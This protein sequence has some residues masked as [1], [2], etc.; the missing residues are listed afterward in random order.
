MCLRVSIAKSEAC[1]AP[2]DGIS[3]YASAVLV[4]SVLHHASSGFYCYGRYMWTHEM[5]YLLGC[6]GSSFF[7]VGALYC[8]MFAGDKAMVS[9]YH[10]FDQSTSG[11]PFQNS[12][13]YRAKKKAL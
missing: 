7:A 13:S 3:P 9:R 5:G 8:V 4:V 12:E 6:L 1:L 10:H 11:F 2:K